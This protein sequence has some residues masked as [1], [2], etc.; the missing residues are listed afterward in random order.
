MIRP[1]PMRHASRPARSVAWWRAAGRV[2]G[3]VGLGAGVIVGSAL[4]SNAFWAQAFRGS[5]TVQGAAA[6]SVVSSSLEGRLQPGGEAVLSVRMRN[7]DVLPVVLSGTASLQSARAGAAA[8]GCPLSVLSATLE[9][10]SA[11]RLAP[12]ST[13]E[14]RFT[15]HLAPNAPQACQGTRLPVRL[16]TRATTA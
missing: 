1:R 11:S 8:A 16:L 9:D 5:V 14:V 13:T 3:A 12:G 4:V 15:L 2:L 10:G 7:E 6:V